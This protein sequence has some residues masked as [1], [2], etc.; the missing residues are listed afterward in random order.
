MAPPGLNP[1]AASGVAAETLN[2]P[3]EA[4]D[5]FNARHDDNQRDENKYGD[6]DQHQKPPVL[7]PDEAPEK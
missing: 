1:A 7:L 3:L 5:D 4:L 6:K 2:G